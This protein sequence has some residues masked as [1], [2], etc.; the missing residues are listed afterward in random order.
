MGCIQGNTGPAPPLGEKG[1]ASNSSADV[2]R[3]V[4]NLDINQ[5]LQ[6]QHTEEKKIK[7][8]IL[9][10]SGSSGKSTLFGQ[11]QQIF[12]DGLDT[13]D[14]ASSKFV[15]RSNCIICIIALLKHTQMF[16]EMKHD[17]ECHI[18]LSRNEYAVEQ[19]Q[20]VLYYASS[21]AHLETYVADFNAETSRILTEA[22][23]YLWSLT[24]IRK[25]YSMRQ[26]Y[27]F[28]ENMDYFFD[29]IKTIFSME[30]A[31]TLK[32]VLKCRS[33]TIGWVEES[34][35]IK[36][37][38]CTIFDAGGQRTERRKWIELFDGVSNV[39]F[40]AA[41]NHYCTVLFE[42]EC[43]N[44]M[45]ESLELFDEVCN[46]RWLR[47]TQMVL[48][49]NKNDLF[50]QRL[51]EGLSL[52]IS[53]GSEWLGPDYSPRADA[54]EEEDEAEFEKCYHMAIDFIRRRYVNLNKNP[55]KKIHVFV[56]TATDRKSIKKV[57]DSIL[58]L[59][60]D[61]ECSLRKADGML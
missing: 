61:R 42:D 34:F 28:V 10:G 48:F 22:I 45:I 1:S 54:S 30:Y 47:T 24:Q 29:N 19:I 33:R 23:G 60:I 27:A 57:F 40:V 17:Q 20:R 11:L 55:F 31:P 58:M 52:S 15:I 41:L 18:D 4:T 5:Y 13:N 16:Y 46:Q 59:L 12:K 51:R 7:K 9:L 35:S 25:A 37:V 3:I 8:I 36:G 26:Y 2:Q 43:K 14:Y 39:I 49:L 50:R 38:P 56:T 32:D 44:S 6:D 21:S 53:F